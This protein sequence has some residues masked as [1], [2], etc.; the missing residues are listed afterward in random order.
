MAA[1]SL[2]EMNGSIERFCLFEVPAFKKRSVYD[3][4]K[5]NYLQCT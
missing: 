4:I 3:K 5:D 2:S 1:G